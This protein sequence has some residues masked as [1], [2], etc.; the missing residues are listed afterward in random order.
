MPALSGPSD[1]ALSLALASSSVH[2]SLASSSGSSSGSGLCLGFVRPSDVLSDLVWAQALPDLASCFVGRQAQTV[3]CPCLAFFFWLGVRAA[4]QGQGLPSDVV[5]LALARACHQTDLGLTDVVVLAFRARDLVLCQALLACFAR[6][7]PRRL[8]SSFLVSSLPLCQLCRILPSSLLCPCHRT[9]PGFVW[10]I[11]S[12]SFL[13]DLVCFSSSI[14]PSS[15][16]WA[17]WPF[18]QGLAL[19]G[20]LDLGHLDGPFTWIHFNFP[21]PCQT[22]LPDAFRLGFVVV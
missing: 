9:V 15:C 18:R 8:S 12:L 6:Q 16:F 13:P 2:P 3:V 14:W 17:V 20:H 7:L 10:P 4:G 5:G 22:C 19:T 21:L 11:V 1:R